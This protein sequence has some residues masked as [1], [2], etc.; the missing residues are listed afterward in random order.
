M[1]IFAR[2]VYDLGILFNYIKVT[3]D[4]VATFSYYLGTRVDDTPLTKSY[5]AFNDGL[6][7]YHSLGLPTAC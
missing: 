5:V 3:E 7:A 2:L 4:D 6:V 1:L